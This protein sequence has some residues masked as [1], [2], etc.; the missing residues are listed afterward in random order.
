MNV[1]AEHLRKQGYKNLVQWLENENHI[2]IGRQNHY[3]PGA[4]GSKWANPFK[5]DQYGRD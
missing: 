2:Y 5:V 1:K 4:L 3:V